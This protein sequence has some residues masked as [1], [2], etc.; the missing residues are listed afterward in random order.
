MVPGAFREGGQRCERRQIQV[1]GIW[2]PP[3]CLFFYR[4]LLVIQTVK[5][6]RN[7][8]CCLAMDTCYSDAT[9]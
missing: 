4:G 9:L 7:A 2:I 6:L 3:P 1:D 8:F 5:R